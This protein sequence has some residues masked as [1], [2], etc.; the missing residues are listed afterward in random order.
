MKYQALCK[1]DVDGRGLSCTLLKQNTDV[2]VQSSSH[3]KG[4]GLADLTHVQV[5]FRAIYWEK[6]TT[7]LDCTYT[8][9]R[10]KL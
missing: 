3:S 8:A 9:G 1:A 10:E 4:Y 2:S 7:Q 5:D 6:S